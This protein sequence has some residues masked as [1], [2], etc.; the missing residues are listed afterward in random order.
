MK[1]KVLS[2]L[3]ICSL[4][5][6]GGCGQQSKDQSSTS[7]PYV[8]TSMWPQEIADDIEMVLG[9]D[10]PFY[11]SA[12]SYE[13]QITKDEFGDDLLAIYCTLSEDEKESAD[14]IYYNMC[15]DAGYYVKINES[16]YFDQSTMTTY[17]YTYVSADKEVTNKLGIE[18]QFLISEYKGKPCLGIFGFTYI[19][20]P[21]D[22]WPTDLVVS[23]LGFDI[24][25]IEREGLEYQSTLEIDS[26][27]D[28][29]VHIKIKNATVSDETS[30][31]MLLE[32][33]EYAVF[34]EDY[35]VYGYM[36]F[37]EAFTHAI[38]FKF[39]EAL[40]NEIEVYI[41]KMTRPS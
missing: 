12:I 35:E 20:A 17:Y 31:A 9:Y 33:L 21:K 10:I 38:Q 7:E 1:R 5:L 36:C 16:S 4:F 34:G 30:Y 15:E 14:D 2:V 22:A 13:S 19:I 25:K 18:L 27:G 37:D 23:L 6:L 41:F 39:N 11:S 40:G 28:V 24:P 8:F 29:F 3:A 26:N 32:S